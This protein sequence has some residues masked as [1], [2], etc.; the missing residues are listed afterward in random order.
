LE[1]RVLLGKRI[2]LVT[3]SNLLSK[4][5]RKK[6]KKKLLSKRTPLWRALLAARRSHKVAR[7]FFFENSGREILV[8]EQR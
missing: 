2:P 5:P 6:K 8:W 7:I 3:V 1:T 4:R